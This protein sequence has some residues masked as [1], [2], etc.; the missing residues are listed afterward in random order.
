V[1]NVTFSKRLKEE[2]RRL[3]LNQLDFGSKGGISKKTQ[4]EYE[5][6]G[7]PEFISYLQRLHNIGA[8][9]LYIITGIRSGASI[10]TSEERKILQIYQ[11]ENPSLHAAALSI[12]TT[13]Q[14]EIL[15]AYQEANASLRAAALA[16]LKSG[17][18]GAAPR[19][20]KAGAS[21]SG[22]GDEE[23]ITGEAV[24]KRKKAS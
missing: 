8:D 19:Q 10:L 22:K 2:R 24:I 20:S 5:R 17:A 16:V 18:A 6:T 9:I 13:K 23:R 12:L 1:K 7:G 15:Q 4:G 11:G 3:K 21:A 14:Q